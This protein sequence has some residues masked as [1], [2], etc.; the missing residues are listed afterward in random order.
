MRSTERTRVWIIG[1]LLEGRVDLV[2]GNRVVGPARKKTNATDRSPNDPIG[3]EEQFFT[4][5]A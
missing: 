2:R 5:A 3:G 4:A 1:W